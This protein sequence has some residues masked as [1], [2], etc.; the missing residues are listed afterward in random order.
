LGVWRSPGAVAAVRPEVEARAAADPGTV[1][2]ARSALA[3]ALA[4]LQAVQLA[5]AGPSSPAV[6][7]EMLQVLR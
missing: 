3:E 4:G 6:G 1:V 7:S 2:E 5:S